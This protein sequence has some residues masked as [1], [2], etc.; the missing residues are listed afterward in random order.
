MDESDDNA[1]AAPGVRESLYTRGL[2]SALAASAAFGFAQSCFY[3]LPKYL[4]EEFAAGPHQV[5][6]VMATFGIATLA[7][8]PLV[9]AWV[10]R[11]ARKH[12]MMLGA[13]LMAASSAGFVGVDE[14]GPAMIALRIFHGIAFC[15]VFVA[16]GA[17]TVDLAPGSRLSEALGLAGAS[18]LVMNAVAPGVAEPLARY[19]GWQAVFM[20]ASASAVVS[21]LMAVKIPDTNAASRRAARDLPGAGGY[22][23]AIALVA[24]MRSP[25]T[26]HYALVV[27][28][29]GAAF[30]VMFTF[31]QPFALEQGRADVSGFFIAYATTAIVIRLGFGDLPDRLG[32]MRVSVF[33]FNLYTVVV[34]GAAAVRPEFLEVIG[35]LLGVAHGMFFPAFN[36]MAFARVDAGS[37]GKMMSVFAAAFYGGLALGVSALAGIADIAGYPAVFVATSGVLM[38]AGTLLIFSSALA[39]Q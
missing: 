37:R 32:R 7:A 24:M 13:L 26:F 5:G 39:E 31:G 21:L 6:A 30:G 25:A 12:L 9:A 20:L 10:D 15:I 28:A 8:V 14:I 3:L 36:A 33:A 34:L 29:I 18:M 4:I 27:A 22:A 35:A 1:R 38:V 23:D 11:V 19:A 16:I 17:L 2:M